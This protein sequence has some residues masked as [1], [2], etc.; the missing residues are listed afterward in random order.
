MK[1]LYLNHNVRGRG[2]YLRAFHLARQLVQRGHQVTLCTTSPSA[3]WLITAQDVD[4]VEII[5]APDL[6][7]G[8]GRTGWDPWNALRRMLRLRHRSF[9]L[10]HAFDSRPVV[11]HPAMMLQ[12]WTGAGLVMDWADWWGRGGWIHDRSG[13]AVR[14]MFGPIETWY[15]E[16]FRR[17]AA[18]TT[19]IST[20]LAR[21]AV[22]LGVRPETVMLLPNGCDAGAI[23]PASSADARRRLQVGSDVPLL[24]HV[25]L[26]T[27]GD[28][29]LLNNAFERARREIPG[30]RLV[31]VGRTG[32]RP[33]PAA[34]VTVT[35]T[36]DSH[37]LADWLAAADACVIPCRDTIGNRGRWP[38][39]VNDYL[40]AGRPVV[41]PQV[42]DVA[43]LLSRSGAGWCTTATAEGLAAGMVDA[44]ADGQA[45]ERAARAARGLAERLDWSVLAGPLESFY[46]VC[47]SS[48]MDPSQDL[49][50]SA[51]TTS[52]VSAR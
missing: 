34:G 10:I 16:H 40:A 4:G 3:R 11:V 43:E 24:V 19:A 50:V 49:T 18:G 48:S 31:L 45:R 44:L 6:L 23:R 13:W 37:C 9:D 33:R 26:L 1:L 17:Q 29:M 25:G 36:V 7:I 38:S 22:D 47:S 52:Q 8:R 39:K 35:G 41:M 2:T 32:I 42:G 21:R 5:E 12:R 27:F 15:E 51:R 30:A 28:L 14:T 46:Q 20:A